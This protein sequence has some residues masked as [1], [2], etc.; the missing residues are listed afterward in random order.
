MNGERLMHPI[1]AN[2]RLTIDHVS[3]P[4]NENAALKQLILSRGL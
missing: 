2:D 4:Y 3:G 1:R